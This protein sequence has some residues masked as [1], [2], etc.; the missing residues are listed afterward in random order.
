VDIVV[1]YL[2]AKR[3]VSEMTVRPQVKKSAYAM[4]EKT[5]R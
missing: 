4:E 5:S 2:R 1:L 3:I